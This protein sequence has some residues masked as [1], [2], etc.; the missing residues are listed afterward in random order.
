[1]STE[2]E[3]SPSAVAPDFRDKERHF[4][5]LVTV[6]EYRVTLK[7]RR[8]ETLFPDPPDTD[9]GR[10]ARL[11]VLGLFYFPL[12]HKYFAA[13]FKGCWKYIQEQK[14]FGP[15]EDIDASIQDALRKRVVG[16]AIAPLHDL[17][18]V[19][20]GLPPPAPTP[21]QAALEHW[22]KIRL[23]GGYSFHADTPKYSRWKKGLER[24]ADPAYP[25]RFTQEL[26]DVEE[27]FYK[28]NPVLG[29]IPIVAQVSRRHGEAWEPVADVPVYFQLVPPYEVPAWDPKQPFLKQYSAPPAGIRDDLIDFWEKTGDDATKLKAAEFRSRR[30][31]CRRLV[32]RWEN[33]R[34]DP[35]DPQAR[36]C[37]REFGGKRGNPVCG[38][39]GREN[40]FLTSG[41]PG[42]NGPHPN[43]ALAHAVFLSQA[44]APDSPRPKHAAVATTDKYGQA[45]AVF[46][47]SRMG[48][49]RYRLRAYVGSGDRANAEVDTGTLAVWRNVRI[50]Q[51]LEQTIRVQGDPPEP[52]VAEELI[53]DAVEYWKRRPLKPPVSG[54][55]VQK[56]LVT[57]KSYSAMTQQQGKKKVRV[58]AM[59]TALAQ[60]DVTDNALQPGDDEGVLPR[61]ARAYCEIE[62]DK[63]ARDPQLSSLPDSL[64]RDRWIEALNAAVRD[65]PLA[66]HNLRISR[67][68][69]FDKLLCMDLILL[70]KLDVDTA[71]SLLPLR[72]P[73][74]Y[75]RVAGR[76]LPLRG[77]DSLD[78]LVSSYLLPSFL[79]G[80]S[81]DG[82]LPGLT[83]V[84][85]ALACS[86]QVLRIIKRWAIALPYR[87]FTVIAAGDYGENSEMASHELG[88]CLFREHGPKAHRKD[89]KAGGANPKEHDP[90]KKSP[91]IMSYCD[92]GPLQFC[93]KC[94]VALRGWDIRKIKK[95]GKK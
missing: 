58:P 56:Y 10:A 14:L 79:A 15:S 94:L 26:F 29:K 24:Q 78:D 43:R 16:P 23:P 36:N 12:N 72:T 83:L 76:K 19:R 30:D 17:K 44:K 59:F 27:R 25:T 95:T 39:S 67:P 31:A 53:K 1:M 38:S 71:V 41:M 3:R 70:K 47:P 55:D 62:L 46:M 66:L 21:E 77:K 89:R 54:T 7:L 51:Y 20:E 63:Q 2:S 82:S 65:G 42:F 80:L 92:H 73:E 74:A 93:A 18:S 40:V 75:R 49:D 13:A 22:A 32:G 57:A 4:N 5:T 8:I 28:D 48:G 37:H 91:C 61:F 85:G 84:T 90:D 68:V 52:V 6:P 9:R 34:P 81:S 60:V 45:G 33:H 69:D 35:G 50:S 11:Q 64:R 88:H 87:G 86:W